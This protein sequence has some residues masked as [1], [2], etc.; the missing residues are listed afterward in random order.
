MTPHVYNTYMKQPNGPAA[1][2]VIKTIQLVL[3][4]LG[5]SFC[6]YL[7]LP[8]D[9]LT[10]AN[11]R[12]FADGVFY[13]P[14]KAVLKQWQNEMRQLFTFLKKH[15]DFIYVTEIIPNPGGQW[16]VGYDFMNPD[17][18]RVTLPTY[19]FIDKTKIEKL[20]Q[21][22]SLATLAEDLMHQLSQSEALMSGHADHVEDI[23]SGVILGYPEKAILS[24]VSRFDQPTDKFPEQLVQANIRGADYY[25]GPQPIYD[26]PRKLIHD[27]DIKKHEELWSSILQDYYTS[28]FHTTLMKDP[29]F[30]AKIK[31]LTEF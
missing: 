23:T 15:R 28:T 8:N 1:A 12:G 2:V 19:S 27:P 9:V 10:L 24:S 31:A 22:D 16:Y 25:Q 13:H 4:N 7:V 3:D 18:L 5:P 30:A 20:V 14:D 26:Y 6:A 21:H 17:G 29:A 11:A